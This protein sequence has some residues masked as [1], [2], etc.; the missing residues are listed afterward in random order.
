MASLRPTSILRL[1][2]LRYSLKPPT[3]ASREP[4]LKAEAFAEPWA[5]ASASGPCNLN[6]LGGANLPESDL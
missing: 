6:V 3:L 4:C 1:L 5:V 2:T